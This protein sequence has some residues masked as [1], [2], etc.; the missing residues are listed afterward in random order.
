MPFTFVTLDNPAPQTF[1][2]QNKQQ[3]IQYT[4]ETAQNDYERIQKMVTQLTQ[5]TAND[6]APKH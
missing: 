6:Y 2:L 5:F 3:T 1:H 4:H